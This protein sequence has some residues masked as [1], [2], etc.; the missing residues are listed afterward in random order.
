[1][2]RRRRTG[3]GNPEHETAETRVAEC[4]PLLPFPSFQLRFPPPRLFD[5]SL[6]GKAA[7]NTDL[8]LIPFCTSTTTRIEGRRCTM[9]PFRQALL[10]LLPLLAVAQNSTS[11]SSLSSASA[12]SASSTITGSAI[13]TAASTTATGTGSSTSTASLARPTANVTNGA[14]QTL[15]LWAPDGGLVQCERATFTFEGPAVSK[16]VRIHFVL[17]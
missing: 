17:S 6:R 15:H 5:F 2:Q 1:L 4:R 16:A 10:A 11:S 7:P 8:L 12:S 9:V 13:V 14:D 3:D